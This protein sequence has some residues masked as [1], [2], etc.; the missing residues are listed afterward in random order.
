MT[1]VSVNHNQVLQPGRGSELR[2]DKVLLQS[3]RK[4]IN[5]PIAPDSSRGF[6]LVAA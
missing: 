3:S 2:D 4:K 5:L 6:A 1:D